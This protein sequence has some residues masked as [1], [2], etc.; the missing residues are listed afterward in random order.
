MKTYNIKFPTLD[1]TQLGYGYK[2]NST[3]RDGLVS[4]LYLLLLTQKGERYYMPEFGTDLLKY[5]FEPN[6][7][8]T[9]KDIEKSLKSDVE[10]FLPEVSINSFNIVDNEDGT[11]N[12][13]KITVFVEFRIKTDVLSKSETIEIEF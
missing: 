11:I 7:N 2:M 9:I 1:D 8:I 4:N 3:T 6:D 12:E 5:I 10:K 13:N